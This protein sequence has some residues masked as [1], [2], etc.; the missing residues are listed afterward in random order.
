MEDNSS[1]IL[2]GRRDCHDCVQQLIQL[3]SQRVYIIGPQLEPELYNDRSIYEQLS[4]LASNN[5]NTDIR[6]IAHDTR[7]AASQ[8][9]CLIHLA[10]RLPSFANIRTTVTREHR[11]FFESW[12]IVDDMAYMRIKNLGRYE[13]NFELD[14]K[15][16]TR[17]YLD[18]FEEIWEACQVDQ[19][20]R[21]LSL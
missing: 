19:N 18:K 5:R 2:G 21:R 4:N 15:L 13:G 8:G 20:T 9:H 11:K 7:V 3:A 10:Q 14:N 12:L 16:E 1:K 6:I 17:S